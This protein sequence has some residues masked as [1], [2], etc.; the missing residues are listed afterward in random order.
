M[1]YYDPFY[2]FNRIFDELVELR[3][4]VESN[5]ERYSKGG[6]LHREDGP[7]LIKYGKDG[8]VE[9]EEYYLEGVKKTKEEVEAYRLD[10]EDKKQHVIYLGDKAYKV[11]GKKLK[12]LTKSLGLE[13]LE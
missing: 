12:E 10:K 2:T 13:P 9:S 8:K 3:T 7:S 4:P 5:V 1:R 11:T 6:L